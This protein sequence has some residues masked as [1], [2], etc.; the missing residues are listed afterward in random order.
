MVEESRAPPSSALGFPLLSP[1]E[2]RQEPGTEQ[3]GAPGEPGA[4]RAEQLCPGL[5]NP[6]QMG[7]ARPLGTEAWSLPGY[8]LR[9]CQGFH[10]PEAGLSKDKLM[11]QSRAPHPSDRKYRQNSGEAG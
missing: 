7:R 1:A 3:R 5:H 10:P 2:Q 6:T 4:E 9:S 11:I 8:S